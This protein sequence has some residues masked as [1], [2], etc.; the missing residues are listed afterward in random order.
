MKVTEVQAMQQKRTSE[1][2]KP[3]EANKQLTLFAA[4]CFFER[5][6]NLHELPARKGV[7]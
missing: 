5:N 2:Q 3:K 7:N 6:F 4:L 1:G